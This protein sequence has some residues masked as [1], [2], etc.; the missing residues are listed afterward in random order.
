[1]A[2]NNTEKIQ[3]ERKENVYLT[4]SY[5]ASRVKDLYI[6]RINRYLQET[7]EIHLTKQSIAALII[8]L[9]YEDANTFNYTYLNSPNIENVV[10]GM[11]SVMKSKELSDGFVTLL[12]SQTELK[13]AI[14]TFANGFFGIIDPEST[15]NGRMAYAA[16]VCTV[17]GNETI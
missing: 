13:S 3:K 10:K 5:T 12:N 7:D 17:V 4:D 1:M 2:I 9:M 16:K 11:V 14:S 8:N 15:M 6:V